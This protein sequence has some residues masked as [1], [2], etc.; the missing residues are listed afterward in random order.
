LQRTFAE[1]Q[2]ADLLRVGAARTVGETADD[3]LLT[4]LAFELQQVSV[5]PQTYG[6]S[7][8][9]AIRPLLAPG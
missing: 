6:A 1:Q 3:A 7:A 8:R 2:A 5:R 9:L 4:L